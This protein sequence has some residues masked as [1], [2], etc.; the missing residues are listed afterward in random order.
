MEEPARDG[1][2]V[3]GLV[4]GGVG[5]VEAIHGRVEHTDVCHSGGD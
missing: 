5:A 3:E 1:H 4:D 2:A